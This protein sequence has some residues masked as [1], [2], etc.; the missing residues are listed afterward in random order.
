MCG[1]MYKKR[2]GGVKMS[3]IHWNTVDVRQLSRRSGDLFV[4]I[5]QGRIA[6]SA[7]ACRLIENIYETNAI[8]I[9]EII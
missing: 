1:I 4:S 2:C 6:L 8:T 9:P 5:G 3:N 7:T